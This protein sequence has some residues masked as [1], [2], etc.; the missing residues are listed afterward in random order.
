M[1]TVSKD[2]VTEGISKIIFGIK[3]KSQDTIMEELKQLKSDIESYRE[4]YQ[5][6]TCAIRPCDAYKVG[7]RDCSG[8]K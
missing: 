7:C 3:L 4:P 6:S 2:L 1:A 8:W 5:C